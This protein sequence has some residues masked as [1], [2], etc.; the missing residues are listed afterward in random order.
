MFMIQAHD[1]VP[2][3]GLE[4]E[5]RQGGGLDLPGDPRH[6]HVLRLLRHGLCHRLAQPLPVPPL[7]GARG[8]DSTIVPRMESVEM[9]YSASRTS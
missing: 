4:Q 8:Q 1:K 3:P 2:G 7:P 5:L 9:K 6:H